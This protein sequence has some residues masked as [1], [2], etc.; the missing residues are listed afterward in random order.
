MIKKILISAFTLSVAAVALSAQVKIATIDMAGCF[1]AFHETQTVNQRMDSL[2]ESLRVELDE[3]QR[4]LE[5]KAQPIQERV[6][7]IQENPGLSAEAKQ[8]QLRSLQSEIEPIQR[9]EAELNQYA[10]QKQAE[11]RERFLRSRQSII[12]KISD[13]A[14]TVAIREGLDLVLDTSDATGSGVGTVIYS[15]RSLDITPKVITELNR[16][17]PDRAEQPAPAAN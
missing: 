16:N 14:R 4:A 10:Q 3:R 15:E 7:E 13:A 9:E 1:D 8:Q 12:D 2:R 11:F 6:Q 17:A 5:E